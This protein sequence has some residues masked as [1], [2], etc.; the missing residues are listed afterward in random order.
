MAKKNKQQKVLECLLKH[1]TVTCAQMAVWFKTTQRS[2]H[3]YVCRLRAEG[4][5]IAYYRDGSG[6]GK[7]VMQTDTAS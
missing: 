5:H 1:G 6:R 3:S 7:Y 2:V 4:H